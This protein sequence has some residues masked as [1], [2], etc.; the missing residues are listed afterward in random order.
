MLR[1]CQFTVLFLSVLVLI[2]C[3]VPPLP[4]THRTEAPSGT[5]LPDLDFIQVGVTTREQVEQNLR[6]LD[7]GATSGMFW[8]RYNHSIM[9]DPGGSRHW[10][11]TN[12]LITYDDRGVVKT[13]R[14]EGD[15]RMNLILLRWLATRPKQDFRTEVRLEATTLSHM[16][17]GATRMPIEL[18]LRQDNF[19]VIGR[20]PNAKPYFH[21]PPDSI[22][23]IKSNPPDLCCNDE[24]RANG[25]IIEQM[26]IGGTAYGK[27]P[28]LVQVSPANMVVLID[29]LRQ[30]APGVRYE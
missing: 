23:R 7:T 26:W 17:N 28:L 30:Y 27:R 4:L 24:N 25:E 9:S 18:V 21:A 22:R 11:R 5:K 16:F 10:N 20:G 8:G 14:R 19:G 2:A 13:Q 6:S 15:D 3:V 12:L 29:Y 1:R